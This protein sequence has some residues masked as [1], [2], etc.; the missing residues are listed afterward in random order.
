[1]RRL[2][3]AL[4]RN[5]EIGDIST[6]DDPSILEELKSILSEKD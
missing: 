6:L 1:M 3:R 5:E 4:V 2:I